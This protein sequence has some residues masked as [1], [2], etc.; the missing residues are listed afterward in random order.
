SRRQVPCT[1]TKCAS[2]PPLRARKVIHT[3]AGVVSI[4]VGTPF[5]YVA[6]HVIQA[7]AICLLPSHR[8]RLLFIA[9]IEIPA[10]RIQT[11]CI[12]SRRARP[13][14]VFPLRLSWQGKDISLR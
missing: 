1:T 8:L 13:A 10:H 2:R 6:V 7:P 3:T 9:I 14:G 11:T 5:P 4:P 12:V